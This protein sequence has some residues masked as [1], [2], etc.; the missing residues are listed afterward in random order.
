MENTNNYATLDL[1]GER[2][3]KVP[4]QEAISSILRIADAL[5][6]RP[7]RRIFRSIQTIQRRFQ[8]SKRA[9]LD[10]RIKV[11]RKEL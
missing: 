10:Q 7:R 3:T 8:W 9:R 6:E 1:T 5:D 4:P 2:A 11:G